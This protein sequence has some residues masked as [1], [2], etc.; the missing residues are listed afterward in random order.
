LTA[1]RARLTSIRSPEDIELQAEALEIS[2]RNLYDLVPPG[3]TRHGPLDKRLGPQ[4]GDFCEVCGQ[5]Q[6]SC[7]GH[8]GY[9]PLELPCFHIG[10]LGFTLEILNSICKVAKDL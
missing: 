1:V 5:E 3:P 8:W 2:D 4:K 6:K 9:I 10:F 7:N